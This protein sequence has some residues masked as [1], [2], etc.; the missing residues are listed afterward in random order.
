VTGCAVT[1]VQAQSAPAPAMK[2]GDRWVYNVKSGIGLKTI[3]YQETRE[4]VSLSGKGGKVKIT[5][6]SADGKDFTR[7]E[8]Y[9][10]PGVISSGALCFDEVY[11]FPTPLPRVTFPV[12]P[13]QRSAKWVDVITVPGGAKGQI[14]YFFRTRSWEKLNM[15]AGAFDAIRVD[16][17]MMLDD[18][19]PFRNS[20]NCNLHV[21][22]FAGGS[23]IRCASGARHSTR[24]STSRRNTA[25]STRSTSSRASRR[26]NSS[27]VRS[28]AADRCAGR[29]VGDIGCSLLCNGENLVL[30]ATLAA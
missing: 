26:G 5:G 10:A 20:T 13:N 29:I 8:D 28:R 16:V 22:V 11:R 4:V 3:S 1:A 21:L 18:A 6:K 17:L 12:A 2:V 27:D 19:T 23:A 25:C 9:S 30:A 7:V 24:N 14:N 15:P